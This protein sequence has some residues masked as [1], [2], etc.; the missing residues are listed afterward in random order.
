MAQITRNC[1]EFV[2]KAARAFQEKYESSTYREDGFIALRSGLMDDCMLVYELGD[3]IGNFVQM[4]PRPVG[5]EKVKVNCSV[6]SCLWNRSGICT[7][8]QIDMQFSTEKGYHCGKY[9]T[10]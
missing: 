2:E 1:M 10:V 8:T 7:A 6:R 9:T 4:F 5:Q 3:E